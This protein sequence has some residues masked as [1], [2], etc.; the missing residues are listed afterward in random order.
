[1][2][3]AGTL[4]QL[5]SALERGWS[6]AWSGLWMGSL[7]AT[8][9]ALAV[10]SV[11][12]ATNVRPATKHGLWLAVL[13]SF[14]T[15][16]V[17]A[18]VW[19]PTWFASERLVVRPSANVRALAVNAPASGV[20]P[21]LKLPAPVERAA[22]LAE[23]P[24][25]EWDLSVP[26]NAAHP[27]PSATTARHDD[28]CRAIDATEST[29]AP[30]RL[31]AP[32][33]ECTPPNAAI[34]IGALLA[35]GTTRV[36]DHELA[37]SPRTALATP[38][39][40]SPA[41]S[42]PASAPLLPSS[43]AF[44]L[45][46]ARLVDLR[47]AIAALPPLPLS[48]WLAGT[49]AV[50]GIYVARVVRVRRLIR[51][52]VPAEGA[53]A[54][55]V[56]QVAQSLGL[57]SAP[58]TFITDDPISPLVWCGISPCIVLPAEMWESFDRAARR[59][60][61]V[62]ELAH[63]RRGDHRVAWLEAAVAAL[64]WWHPIAWIARARVRDASEAACDTWV[65]SLCPQNRRSYAEAI[66]L[67]TSYLSN[68]TDRTARAQQAACRSVSVGFVS[69][70][71][72]RLARRITMIMTS[73]FAPRMSLIGGAAALV[74]IGL[75]AFV[76]PSIACPPSECQ[77]NSAD[78]VRQQEVAAKAAKAELKALE[79]ARARAGRAP[80]A[81]AGSTAGPSD[82]FLAEAPAIDAMGHG[83]AVGGTMPGVAVIAP[84]G[85]EL[86]LLSPNTRQLALPR[87]LG[88]TFATTVE[89]GETTPRRYELPDGKLEAL[90]ELMA[91]EDVP[92][93]IENAGD[94]I[95]LHGTPRQHEIFGAFVALIN[96]G[97]TSEAS[98]ASRWRG[99]AG[100]ALPFK[101]ADFA[102]AHDLQ[103]DALDHLRA[104]LAKAVNDRAALERQAEELREAAE[105]TRE[106]A[107]ELRETR[108][109]LAER[110]ANFARFG[111]AN[112][113]RA[114]RDAMRS[115]ESSVRDV[116]REANT[117]DAQANSAE[118]RMAAIENAIARIED[119]LSQ[120]EDEI[121]SAM[122]E[123]TED[124]VSVTDEVAPEAG[125]ESLDLASTVETTWMAPPAPPA[126][127]AAAAQSA[128]ATPAPALPPLPNATAPAPS[129]PALPPAA[130]STR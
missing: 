122:E 129:Q 86:R 73:R 105:Q 93:F 2:D 92:V 47:D 29:C 7:A 70:R 106:K 97:K 56:E 126:A 68:T 108:E 26:P 58:T 128:P 23:R 18:L 89:S 45:W 95:I 66:V 127:P 78:A 33:D 54:R 42:A 104:E 41:A 43:S 55:E 52:A 74:A 22:P 121:E 69:G 27:S 28:E 107:E 101:R 130:P 123:E 46:L 102:A 96:P 44:H 40:A 20:A 120:L 79:K 83:G 116:E 10:W 50:I 100:S 13:V 124:S 72:R 125:E 19:R 57:D 34:D 76:A 12:R 25:R 85:Q 90:I 91:R 11:S 21:A 82:P 67:A 110:Q 81:A 112:A 118:G 15:P 1:M 109:S 24:A 17:A 51:R 36:P 103:R 75:G 8:L 49:L 80:R 31:P 117:L 111:D 60:V 99:Q 77:P 37:E 38:L 94:A 84:Q 98:G 63:V 5:T 4:E 30:S 39:P 6:L 16:A 48:I 115:L 119:R 53:I 62:H 114:L 64:Y 14:L 59:T 32:T 3:L 9:I 87:G 61:L 71:S 35:A 65:T 113:E 88:G